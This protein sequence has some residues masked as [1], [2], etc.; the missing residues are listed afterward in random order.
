MWGQQAQRRNLED[1]DGC[2]RSESERRRRSVTQLG[3]CHLA[4]GLGDVGL[5]VKGSLE[6]ISHHGFEFAADE[7]D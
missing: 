5:G 3:G 7:G 1:K 4:P 6:K 2:R